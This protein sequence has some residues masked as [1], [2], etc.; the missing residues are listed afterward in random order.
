[1]AKYLHG[2][3]WRTLGKEII[4]EEDPEEVVV[5]SNNE[6]GDIA[7]GDHDDRATAAGGDE[8]ISLHQHINQII[9]NSLGE[10]GR[11]LLV[12]TFHSQPGP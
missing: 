4:E 12:S 2:P 1:M 3:S 8:L 10:P 6:D 9:P 11:I 7:D 5:D